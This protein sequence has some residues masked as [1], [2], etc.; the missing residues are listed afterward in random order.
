MDMWKYR[1]ARVFVRLGLRRFVSRTHAIITKSKAGHNLHQLGEYQPI[2]SHHSKLSFSGSAAGIPDLQAGGDGAHVYHQ[3]C[4]HVE[5][6]RSRFQSRSTIFVAGEHKIVQDAVTRKHRNSVEP[7]A[8]VE[9]GESGV[10]RHGL[11][12]PN[13]PER[14]PSCSFAG[15][16]HGRKKPQLR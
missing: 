4:C 1:R 12:K 7:F 16:C 14:R 3:P 6:L 9:G 8:Y 5:V 13:G 10:V 2:T 15:V 11:W